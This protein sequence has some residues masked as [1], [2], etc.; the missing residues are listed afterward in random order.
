MLLIQ[1]ITAKCS[2]VCI[3]KSRSF[4]LLYQVNEH[5]CIAHPSMF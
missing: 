2:L 4:C 5:V 3:G 1:A